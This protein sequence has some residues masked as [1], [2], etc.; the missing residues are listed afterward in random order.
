MEDGL[1][2]IVRRFLFD[3]ID[4]AHVVFFKVGEDL[5]IATTPVELLLD[6]VV[7]YLF[8]LAAILQLNHPLPL[9]S[10]YYVPPSTAFTLRDQGGLDKLI[11]PI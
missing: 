8:L 5:P 3:V 7:D 9:S 2:N 6:N 4:K 10:C 11:E 1:L